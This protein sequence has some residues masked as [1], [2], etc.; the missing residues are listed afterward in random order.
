HWSV[1][2]LQSVLQEV[3]LL[4]GCWII[5]CHWRA[6]RATAALR[7]RL[8][9]R[10]AQFV[11]EFGWEALTEEGREGF[12]Y[13][14][15]ALHAEFLPI[16]NSRSLTREAVALNPLFQH[17]VEIPPFVDP[18][19]FHA[20]T[21]T[22][23]RRSVLFVTTAHSGAKA[24][25]V[26]AVVQALQRCPQQITV[27]VV[28]PFEGQSVAPFNAA[29]PSD[30][31]AL[32]REHE[33]VIDVS[34][35]RTSTLA[36]EACVS[37]ALPLTGVFSEQGNLHRTEP[38]VAEQIVLSEPQQ[39]AEQL[40]RLL[41]APDELT[42][43]RE[44]RME[45]L[46]ALEVA[47]PEGFLEHL[48]TAVVGY[49]QARRAERS[50]RRGVSLIIP[51]YCALDATV[52]CLRSVLQYAP[53][54]YE[55]IVVNDRSDAGTTRALNEIARSTSRIRLLHKEENEGFVQAC[56][57]GYAAANPEH[58]V[59][60]VNS[61]IVLTRHTLSALADAA[62]A[63]PDVGI[64][65]SLSTNSPHL[66]LQVNPGDSLARAAETIASFGPP[67][68]P[69]VITPEGQLLY[70][71]RWA[72][73][74]FGF[75]DPV[76][77]RGFC[78]ESDLCMR[79]FLHGVDMV[80]AE[81]SLI[82]HRKSESFGMEG[83]REHARAN[84]PIFE[85]RWGRYYWL[86]YPEFL[87]RDPLRE[88]R[89]RYR[90]LAPVIEPPVAPVSVQGLPEQMERLSRRARVS[91]RVASLLDGVEVVFIVPSV[92]LGGGT[93]SVLQHV[94]ELQL[95]GVEARVLTLTQPDTIQ[96]PYLSP[97]IAVSPEQ[98]MELDWSTQHVVAT[99]WLTAYY[100]KALTRRYSGL[101]GYYYVQDYEPWFYSRPDRLPTIREAEQSYHLGLHAVAKTD[102][103][104]QVVQ[105]E[106]G[107]DVSLV[108][109]G[110]ARTV[111]YPGEQD[112]AFGRPSLTA[113]YRPR[114]PRRGGKECTAILQAVKARV[115]EARLQLFG[116]DAEL[117]EE[118]ARCVEPLGRLSQ[119]DVAKLYR[120]SDLVLDVS[121]WHGFGRMGIEGMACGA[122]PILSASG[123][124]ERYAR[125]GENCF[126]VPIERTELAVERIVQ[127]LTNKEL[128]LTLRAAAIATAERFSES[129]AVDDWLDIFEINAPRSWQ[130][131]GSAVADQTILFPGVR[132]RA[133]QRERE[134][135]RVA[136]SAG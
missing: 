121:Y 60:L 105:R 97:P 79:M 132:A 91:T 34:G 17:A 61:D 103:L 134:P 130:N 66:Q 5:A 131:A 62:Y 71:R 19:I 122:V 115:P 35:V 74:S 75:F 73:D 9:G 64:A 46:Q 116:E 86:V 1:V 23:R 14:Q 13:A 38:S 20:G 30:L 65:S 53:S 68:N 31:A 135:L 114:T 102:Y 57:T 96:F 41:D 111:F 48:D 6:V 108:S 25:V 87:A 52:Q 63:R 2:S 106:H 49:D 84:R 39:A 8:R 54:D 7:Y 42:S 110:L 112:K 90:Q 15:W 129:I 107:I 51:V 67:K 27:D 55:I 126:V 50:I 95:R 36:W 128:R 100:V 32:L 24:A 127:L 16:S 77:F 94:N 70:L 113:Y 3:E 125:D 37:G 29:R 80:V 21:T 104:R 98:L 88:V 12:H 109:P 93:L 133:P 45:A 33:I 28:G 11:Q 44:R 59:V 58:D 72:L 118:F 69:T 4:T 120:R 124:I 89:S 83:G 78:E 82:L 56:L 47:F 117:P 10:A 119:A 81:N 76:Y 92:I 18:S 85:A 26:D 40:L 101:K 43:Q 136:N 99:F 22:P 123:G